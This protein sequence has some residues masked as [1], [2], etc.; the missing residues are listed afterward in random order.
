MGVDYAE[1]RRDG[2]PPYSLKKVTTKGGTITSHSTKSIRVGGLLF[3]HLI[4]IV[5]VDRNSHKSITSCI[6]AAVVV[7]VVIERKTMTTIT[8][9]MIMRKRK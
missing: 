5:L 3:Y 1:W 4:G 9:M 6:S 8:M 2:F 7:L